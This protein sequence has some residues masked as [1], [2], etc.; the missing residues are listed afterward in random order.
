MKLVVRIGTGG[1]PDD[2]LL[3]VWDDLV[4]TDSF[5][6]NDGIGF[7][8][9]ETDDVLGLGFGFVPPK[10]KYFTGLR[11]TEVGEIIWEGV[12]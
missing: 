6:F 7:V 1:G 10:P 5:D 4:P 8:L 2:F 11:S 3:L 12:S 9:D